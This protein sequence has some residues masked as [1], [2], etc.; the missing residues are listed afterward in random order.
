MGWDKK[1]DQWSSV[2]EKRIGRSATLGRSMEISVFRIGK[3]IMIFTPGELFSSYHRNLK[4]KFAKYR[5]ILV[6]YCN[7]ESGYLPDTKGIELGGYEV[8]QAYIFFD[9][10]APLHI[11][12]PKIYFDKVVG[13]IEK[14]IDN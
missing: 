1:I 12:A 14:T 5:I 10:P 4:R 8:E 2:Q 7:G 3:V 6:G 9:E 11:S 13:L